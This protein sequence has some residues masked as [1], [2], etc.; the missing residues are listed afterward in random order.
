MES[1]RDQELISTITLVQQS[2]WWPKNSI[3]PSAELVSSYLSNGEESAK[4]DHGNEFKG[5]K[6]GGREVW[7]GLKSG[8]FPMTH[9]GRR[10]RF[11]GPI[12]AHPAAARREISQAWSFGGGAPPRPARVHDG[13]P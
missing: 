13:W 5:S 10:C 4:R 11:A 1:P 3:Q 7:A 12:R 2:M 8:K 9:G 6:N